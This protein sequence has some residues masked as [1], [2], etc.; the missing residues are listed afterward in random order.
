MKSAV[1]H[2]YSK[3]NGPFERIFKVSFAEAQ[4]KVKELKLQKKK[5]AMEKK[6]VNV[7]RKLAKKNIKFRISGLRE[8]DVMLGTRQSFSQ[9]SRQRQSLYFES[10]TEAS[11][12]AQKRK[13]QENLGE[14]KP[15]HHSPS[16]ASVHFE[17]EN[18]LQEAQTMEDGEKVRVFF[19]ITVSNFP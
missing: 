10:S 16:T 17:R 5:D 4:T 8:T 1:K 9:R 15:K 7:E 6:S 19:Q 3:L 18:L 2:I 14:R 12:R 13:N 11:L